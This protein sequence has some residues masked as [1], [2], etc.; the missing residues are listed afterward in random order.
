MRNST[1]RAGLADAYWGLAN[2]A[3]SL[4]RYERGAEEFRQARELYAGLGVGRALSGV[5]V[6]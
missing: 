5:S 6:G 3:V 4:G 2:V 1:N